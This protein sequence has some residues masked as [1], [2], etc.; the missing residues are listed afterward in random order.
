MAHKESQKLN[1]DWVICG[2]LQ[3]V[4][5]TSSSPVTALTP[6]W[7]LCYPSLALLLMPCEYSRV[8]PHYVHSKQTITKTAV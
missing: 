2:W 1:V 7:R 6:V 3:T 5:I 8:G 4:D